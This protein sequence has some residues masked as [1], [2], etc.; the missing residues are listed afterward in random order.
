MPHSSKLS[1]LCRSQELIQEIVHSVFFQ[2]LISQDPM[3]SFQVTYPY[4]V[5]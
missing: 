1:L 4:L 3:F 2:S 5:K